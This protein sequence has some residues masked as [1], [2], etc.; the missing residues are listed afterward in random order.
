[1]ENVSA[2]AITLVGIT[3]VF[4]VFLLLYIIFKLMEIAGIS[5]N[6]KVKIP[7]PKTQN[8]EST[9]G[10]QTQDQN[11][12]Q[13]IQNPQQVTYS[14]T[15]NMAESEEIAA[16][17]GAIYSMLDKNAVIKSITPLNQM[18]INKNKVSKFRK[19]TRGWDEWR[20]Y[21]WRGGNKW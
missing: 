1:M 19:G 11:K 7:E 21:G 16:V 3:T 9:S 12:F 6:R 14:M 20:T 8:L 15:D 2:W 10:S 13:S 4:I 18:D 5:K 17:F